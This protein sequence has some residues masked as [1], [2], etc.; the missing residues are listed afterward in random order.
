MTYR[1]VI[2]PNEP[3]KSDPC[4]RYSVIR[5][6][7]FGS[8]KQPLL[9]WPQLRMR[10][11]GTPGDAATKRCADRDVLC[12]QDAESEGSAHLLDLHP[13]VIA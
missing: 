5:W 8:E 3:H 7:V 13:S 9:I 4:V 6:A 10:L 11:Q 1:H 12:C 2:G